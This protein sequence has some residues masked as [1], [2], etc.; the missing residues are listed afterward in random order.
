MADIYDA[1]EEKIMDILARIDDGDERALEE[2][3][4]MKKYFEEIADFMSVIE[5]G[6]TIESVKK[7]FDK[8]SEKFD[9]FLMDVVKVVG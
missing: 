1:I 2:L 8:L 6:D 4:K 9:E 7:K 5:D 3:K